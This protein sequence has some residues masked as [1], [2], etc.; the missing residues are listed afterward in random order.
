MKQRIRCIEVEGSTTK[1]AIKK[2]LDILGVSRDMVEVK[3]LCEE[4]KGLFGMD[5]QKPAK[6]KVTL[7]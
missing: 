7:K 5:G 1:G 3:I 2:A 4:S 6:V